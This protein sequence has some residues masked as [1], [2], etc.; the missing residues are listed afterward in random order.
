[1]PAGSV[2]RI[3]QSFEL[4]VAAGRYSI[5]LG[6]S[7]A[8]PAQLR[9]YLD[10]HLSYAQFAKELRDV[11]RVIQATWITV[12]P[13]PDRSLPHHGLTDMP[14]TADVSVGRRFVP[15]RVVQPSA[16]SPTLFHVTHWK[17]GSQWIYGILRA[18]APGRVVEPIADDIQVRYSTIQEG[19]VYPTVYLT[20]QELE[21]VTLPAE[22][23]IFVVIRDLRDTLVSAYFSFKISHP[24]TC[25]EQAEL[26]A[27]LQTLDEEEGM[28]YALEHCM[29]G[30]ARIQLSW[31]DADVPVL[32]YE[33]LIR[34][35]VRL[36]S[37]LLID[38]FG[39]PIPRQRLTQ[40]IEA[41][42]FESM[43]GRR[44]GAE[45]IESHMRKGVAGDWRN[46]F[47]ERVKKAFK[48]RY[49]GLLAATGYERDLSW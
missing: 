17:A 24:I 41:A 34:D 26:R 6:L 8:N 33:D 4:R 5:S 22:S 29:P 13:P 25:S 23:R 10:G 31:L 42:R 9:S 43:S 16:L 36:L 28:L 15:A 40:A 1:V 39:M 45:N 18:C 48:A 38:R 35:D 44:R 46:H 30:C 11:C 21:E 20:R 37:E 32:R 12:V 27:V 3:H 19:A 14:G 7:D 2:I 49:G 47:T